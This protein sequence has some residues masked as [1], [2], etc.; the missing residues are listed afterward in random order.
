MLDLEHR[1]ALGRDRFFVVIAGLFRLSQRR[2]ELGRAEAAR[3]EVGVFVPVL[4]KA[5]LVDVAEQIPG[6]RA[7]PG[8]LDLRPPGLPE[9][10]RPAEDVALVA[11]TG[12]GVDEQRR[13][14]DA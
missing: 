3:V 11:E 1:R 7:R 14:L 6:D 12:A 10:P 4:E 9:K 5:R 13:R 8:A 2:P